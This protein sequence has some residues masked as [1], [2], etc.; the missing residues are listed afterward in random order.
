M[1][2]NKVRDSVL[3]DMRNMSMDKSL[4]ITVKGGANRSS[5][6]RSRLSLSSETKDMEGKIKYTQ[7]N[8]RDPEKGL[9]LNKL[10]EAEVRKQILNIMP[11]FNLPSSNLELVSRVTALRMNNQPAIVMK[12]KIFEPVKGSDAVINTGRKRDVVGYH[13]GLHSI[14]GSGVLPY[15]IADMDVDENPASSSFLNYLVQQV[16]MCPQRITIDLDHD[17]LFCTSIV[18]AIASQREFTLTREVSQLVSPLI[19]NGVNIA[20]RQ[21]MWGNPYIVSHVDKSE[22]ANIMKGAAINNHVMEP[23]YYAALGV[24]QAHANLLRNVGN[25]CICTGTAVADTSS[26]FFKLFCN[27]FI[28]ARYEI[29][30]WRPVL[31]NIAPNQTGLEYCFVNDANTTAETFY[32]YSAKQ[33]MAYFHTR[34]SNQYIV[35]ALEIAG[36]EGFYFGHPAAVDSAPWRGL[37]FPKINI[38]Y[39][40]NVA[41][42]HAARDI[43][44]YDLWQTTLALADELFVY[45]DAMR[46]LFLAIELMCGTAVRHSRVGPAFRN[47]P[48]VPQQHQPAY[49]VRGHRNVMD[50]QTA[51]QVA[52]ASK[53]SSN[54]ATG[55]NTATQGHTKNITTRSVTAASRSANQAPASN[56]PMTNAFAGFGSIQQ[57]IPANSATSGA[58]SSATS[59]PSA[60]TQPSS[61]AS[62]APAPAAAN[63]DGAADGADGDGFPRAQNP[64]LYDYVGDFNNSS[65]EDTYNP[66]EWIH[67]YLDAYSQAASSP[68]NAP[69]G[70]N[71][72]Y[73]MLGIVPVIQPKPAMWAELLVMER[74][75]IIKMFVLGHCLIH[76]ASATV[77]A[78]FGLTGYAVDLHMRGMGRR[79]VSM[80]M[81]QLMYRVNMSNFQPAVFFKMTLNVLS[82]LVGHPMQLENTPRDWNGRHLYPPNM[83]DNHGAY[84]YL[85]GMLPIRLE[86]MLCVDNFLKARPREWGI[87]TPSPSGTIDCALQPTFRQ[88]W[89]SVV[90]SH[91][92]TPLYEAR[93]PFEIKRASLVSYGP[94]LANATCQTFYR[95]QMDEI[96]WGYWVATP[97]G[98]MP[99]RPWDELAVDD[100]PPP[101]LLNELGLL[102]PLTVMPFDWVYGRWASLC[103]RLRGAQQSTFHFATYQQVVNFGFSSLPLRPDL[104]TPTFGFS[105]Q[106][107]VKFTS[108]QTRANAPTIPTDNY[109]LSSRVQLADSRNAARAQDPAAPSS[110]SSGGDIGTVSATVVASAAGNLGI[111]VIAASDPNSERSQNIPGSLYAA[112]VPPPVVKPPAKF[113]KPSPAPAT[114]APAVE[115]VPAAEATPSVEPME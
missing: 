11:I 98:R 105:A 72:I 90:A 23:R 70:Y 5:T 45:Q 15:D 108:W 21:L 38:V 27:V 57:P 112:P 37:L 42:D 85:T 84:H 24:D 79:E 2:S 113:S 43:S 92:E 9:D 39:F 100:T 48:L 106:P 59:A 22:Y 88:P 87:F 78:G 54:K 68:Y 44:A 51:N 61:A 40:T 26:F 33:Y 110:S 17:E 10:I 83:A 32:R 13:F 64:D 66:A 41:T 95:N 34:H 63:A 46:G 1:S 52:A 71:W 109:Y 18:N 111:N 60:A 31:P 114:P 47:Q 7:A 81:D 20:P 96:E 19:A 50:S 28:R 16:R 80:I 93:H 107:E 99:N 74:D 94:Q 69:L 55:S 4:A 86:S 115:A 73:R 65:D 25:Q 62:G 104:Q 101:M 14:N 67:I 35:T 29:N 76:A 12:E 75:N 82:D 97:E 58:A 53:K 3:K 8:S 103:F 30:G 49:A 89:A 77:M 6:G 102:E 36:Y 56:A 91:T